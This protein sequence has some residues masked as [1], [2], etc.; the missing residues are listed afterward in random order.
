MTLRENSLGG[1]VDTSESGQG[2][3]IDYAVWDFE[4]WLTSMH[5]YD[6]P[7]AEASICVAK[8]LWALY[9]LPLG[10]LIPPNIS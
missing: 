6:R 7:C 1:G 2:L 5:R 3:Q 9:P 10:Q 8:L 4:S